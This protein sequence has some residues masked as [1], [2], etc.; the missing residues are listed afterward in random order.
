MAGHADVK[1]KLQEAD[2]I[3]L[4]P[5]V[6]GE[7]RAGFM[8]GGRHGKNDEELSLFLASPRVDIVDVTEATSIRYAAILEY[9]W[10]HGLPIPTNGIW[11]AASAMEH[12][13]RVVTTDAHY[14]KVPQVV[15]EC[16]PT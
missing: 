11:I 3:Y 5:V 10:R 15:S 4:N 6:L 9:L 12:G 1:R 16:F 8:K 14:A 7:L 13:L 2:F